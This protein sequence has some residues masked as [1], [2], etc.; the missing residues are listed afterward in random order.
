MV[1]QLTLMDSARINRALKRM[2][3][4]IWEDLGNEKAPLIIGLNERGYATAHSIGTHINSLTGGNSELCKFDV[5]SLSFDGSSPVID[6][7]YVLL[8]DDVIFSGK[9]MFSSIVNMIGDHTVKEL[10][11]VAL[12]DRG[13][14]TLPV[15]ASYTGIEV[16]TKLGEHVDVVVKGQELT[17]VILTENA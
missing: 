6:D 17:E 11:V 14:R 1:Q 16:P 8:V 5:D 12:V 4:E 7:R 3:L 2:A 13:H 10:K 15:Q 9:A